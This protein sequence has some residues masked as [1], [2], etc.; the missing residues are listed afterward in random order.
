MH[1][2]KILLI[3][4]LLVLTGCATTQGTKNPHVLS[5]EAPVEDVIA[6]ADASL[7]ARD[8]QAAVI[9]YQIAI[10]QDP[11]AEFWYK[12]GLANAGLKQQ[13][14]A[15]YAYLQAVALDDRHP[16]AL[17]KLALHYTA[18]GEIKEARK[19]LDAL[20]EVDPRNWKAHNAL[21]VVADLE[22]AF[23]EAREHYVQALQIR[24]DLALLWNNLGYSVYL[25]GELDQ[26]AVYMTRALEL[27]PGHRA[28]KLNLAL[29]RVRQSQFSD[30]LAILSRN[31]ELAKA[32][33]DLGYLSY[34]VGEYEKA[35]E[36]LLEAISQ[37]PTFNRPA[38]SYLAA[39][40]EAMAID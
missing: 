32:Y 31:E 40:R 26:A 25:L 16:G 19:Y 4:A 38:H 14:K 28:A 9:L 18:K 8:F 11:Q 17:E 6:K 13:R 33:T 34:K 29:V 23:S 30:A 10:R 22:E 12:L 20:L 3:A 1:L 39:T 21:G 2:H 24:P 27:D 7:T 35:E 37:S 15:F 36:F 5:G